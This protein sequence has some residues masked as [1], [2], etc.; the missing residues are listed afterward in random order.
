MI[1]IDLDAL[2]DPT[3]DKYHCFLNLL[4]KL[5]KCIFRLYDFSSLF[6]NS[7][8]S[9]KPEKMYFSTLRLFEFNFKIFSITTKL[10]KCIFRL[11]DFTSLFSKLF[12]SL[13]NLKNAYFDC[14]TFPVYFQTLYIK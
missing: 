1:T 13:L 9:N 7:I 8:S 10:E 5:E 2:I 3:K 4:T 14:T 12:L 6:S 11:Y